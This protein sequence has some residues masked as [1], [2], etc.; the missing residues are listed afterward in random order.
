[1][2]PRALLSALLVSTLPLAAA[3]RDVQVKSIDFET[4]LIEL[5]N[6]GA[7]VQPLD[8]WR[9]C[10]HDEDSTRRYTGATGF[11]GK[12][13][14]AGSS[15]FIHFNNDSPGGADHLNRSSLGGFFA[16]PL[17]PGPGG[18]A[19]GLYLNSS[20]ASTGSLADFLQWSLGGID[21]TNADFRSHTAAGVL[22]SD[23]GA[24]ISTTATT[25]RLEL[26]ANLGALNSPADYTA[27]ET[28]GSWIA[29][30]G[31][32][33]E[34]QDP[35][36]DSDAD[37]LDNLTDYGHDLHPSVPNAPTERSLEFGFEDE[38]GT[39]YFY[40]DYTAFLQKTDLTYRG[41]TSDT[42]DTF[43]TSGVEE[44]VLSTTVNQER[45]RARIE[46]SNPFGALRLLFGLG[47]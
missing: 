23:Q 34:D 17:D 11:N 19:M 45:R 24:W 25:S 28:F 42:L 18:Y 20:F 21:D 39:T 27:S 12:S 2:T 41:E 22:W 46:A 44:R 8:G 16:S 43:G 4:G 5:H 40:L 35:E 13:L 3:P 36:D 47:T 32:A 38:A 37:Q 31:H 15:L 7:A 30:Q 26:T 14:A 33:A 9:F 29:A 6:F 10:T 1:M